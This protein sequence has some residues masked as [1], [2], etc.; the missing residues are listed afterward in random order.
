M[1]IFSAFIQ[2]S[3]DPAAPQAGSE[4]SPVLWEA[5][6]HPPTHI[7]LLT[8]SIASLQSHDLRAG[9]H[10]G[11]LQALKLHYRSGRE[12]VE[13]WGKGRQHPLSGKGG[14]GREIVAI[15]EL[16]PVV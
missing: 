5:G 13:P 3:S 14:W 4:A 6:N 1:G 10:P 15:L 9:L 16:I 11:S 2:Q 12:C 8:L 7:A